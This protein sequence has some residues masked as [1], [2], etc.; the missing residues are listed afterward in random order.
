MTASFP[1]ALRAAIPAGRMG[2]VADVSRAVLFLAADE[3]GFVS[4]EILDVNG[5]MW[6]D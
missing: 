3:A 2:T 6:C 1:A 4:G 5:A